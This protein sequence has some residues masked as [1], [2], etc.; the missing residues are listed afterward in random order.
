YLSKTLKRLSFSLLTCA[1]CALVFSACNKKDN[2]SA[3]LSANVRVTNSSQAS[4]PQDFF[5]DN[6]KITA[7]AV[8]YGQST[9]YTTTSVGNRQAAFKNSGTTTVNTSFNV[10]F[11][12][13]KYY[14]VF[15]ADGNSNTALQ[16]D[17]TTPQSGKA[18]VRFIN[19]ASA[20]TANVD[21]AINGGAK[22]VS[23]LAFKG[24]SD[25]YDVDPASAFSLY[26]TGSSLVLLRIPATIQAGHI[27]TIYISG[28]TSAALS[29]HLITEN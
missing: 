16:N 22:L 12:A 29:F 7:S 10:S 17:R 3:A 25:Y 5:M 9:D 23:A 28:A 11:Q 1:L 19:L 18:R 2:G 8:A 27:Y 13:G 6:N 15:Y 26:A 20:V 24:A 14:S 21:F 4:V